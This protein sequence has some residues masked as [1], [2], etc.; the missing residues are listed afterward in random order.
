MAR[1]MG[2]KAMTQEQQFLTDLV[3]MASALQGLDEWWSDKFEE[4]KLQAQELF[5]QAGALK[6]KY[7]LTRRVLSYYESG[8]GGCMRPCRTNLA[9]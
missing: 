6:D 8:M 5:K 1:G 7:A 2:L 3:E 9:T 4:E